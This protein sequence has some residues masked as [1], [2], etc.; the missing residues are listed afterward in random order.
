MFRTLVLAVITA[1]AALPGTAADAITA[2]LALPPLTV[3]A[4]GGRAR[5]VMPPAARFTA[6][7]ALASR[8]HQHRS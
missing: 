6:A 7:P 2:T 8:V 5:E 3:P 1:W 4:A